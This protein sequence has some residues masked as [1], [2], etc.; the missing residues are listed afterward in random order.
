[1]EIVNVC[2]HSF[3]KDLI[4]DPA[5]V[6]DCGANYGEFSKWIASNCTAVIH[7]FEPD[8]RLFPHLP[9]LPETTFHQV[10]VSGS[11]MPLLLNLGMDRCSSAYYREDEK[12]E[13]VDV[14]SVTIDSFCY[15]ERISQVD[16]LK[17]DIEGA[18]IEILR[19]LPDGLLR[20]IGQMTV[21]F[22]DFLDARD[23][24]GI[25]SVMRRLTQMG[26]HCVKFSHFDH[27]DVLFINTSIHPISLIE[28]T[29]LTMTKY[30]R[31]A[32]RLIRRLVRTR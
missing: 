22:H 32:L 29:S 10:A 17:L 21:E 11:G 19:N 6:I 27:A 4:K 12:Q 14:P 20:Q 16:L 3:V 15:R 28:V 24:P 1:M 5:L 18:E 25:K 8:P 26:F 7:G 30:W 23:I 13:F 2:G 31:G 9:S